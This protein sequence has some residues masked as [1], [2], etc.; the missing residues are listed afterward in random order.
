MKINHVNF[1]RGFRGGERQTLSL[2]SGLARLGIQQTLICRTGSTLKERA[3]AL[4]FEIMPTR[5]PMLGHFDAPA[6]DITHVHEARGAYWAAIEHFMLRTPYIITRR[7]PN[8][9]SNSLLTRSV[10]RNA[11][12]LFGVSSDVSTRLSQQVGRNV[13][14]VLSCATQYWPSL[15]SVAAIRQELGGGPVI[16]HVGALVD[17]H[18]GQSI[19]LEAF[20]KLVV[21]F[22]Q[23]RLLFVGDGPDRAELERLAKGNRRI[24]FAGFQADVGP[25]IAAMD[26]FAFPSR[27]EGLG[28]SVLDAMALGVPVVVSPVGGL[29][30]LTG[31]NQRGLVI[32]RLNAE[33]LARSIRALLRDAT[34]RQQLTS[35]ARAFALRHDA[36]EMAGQYMQVYHA[37]LT[38]QMRSLGWIDV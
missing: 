37:I 24:R 20:N 26:I 32:D 11:K 14:T 15:A 33:S 17:R 13:R 30:E 5:H 2:M 10:Y 19:L 9:I 28:S 35:E 27:E 34:L 6:A 25:W 29:P 8:P 4:G 12:A 23:A 3:E 16:G 1:A 38:Q 7:V 31:K 18:K 22:P 21:E 36:D